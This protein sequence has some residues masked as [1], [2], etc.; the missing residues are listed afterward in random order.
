MKIVLLIPME[1]KVSFL[2]H[3]IPIAFNRR[4]S[5]YKFFLFFLSSSFFIKQFKKIFLLF[6][7]VISL[8][9]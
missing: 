1:E 2:G 6:T 9:F 8:L 4:I 3:M 5:V 7:V